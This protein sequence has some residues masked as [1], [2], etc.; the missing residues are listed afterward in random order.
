MDGPSSPNVTELL[1]AWNA[2]D[3]QAQ[4]E[5]IAVIY[6]ELRRVAAG[7]LH[8]ER[9][10]HTLQ[11]TALVNEAFMRLIDGP[12]VTWQNRAHFFGIAANAMRQI[13]VDYARKRQAQKRGSGEAPLSLDET[14]G[15]FQQRAIDLVRLDDALTQLAQMDPTQAQIVELRFFAGLTIEETAEALGIS[16]ATIGREWT[17]ARLWLRRELTRS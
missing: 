6:D 7:Y 13:L 14:F 10:N 5:L 12:Q 16:P 3:Q 11:P 8:R 17:S 1:L 15:V 2:G 4:A 9:P